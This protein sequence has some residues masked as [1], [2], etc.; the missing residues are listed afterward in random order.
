MENVNTNKFE[1]YILPSYIDILLLQHTKNLLIKK[2]K[3]EKFL[4]VFQQDMF[5]LL[6][7]YFLLLHNTIILEICKIT[8][9]PQREDDISLISFLEEKI[10]IDTINEIY[11]KYKRLRDKKI[12][13]L[14]TIKFSIKKYEKKKTNYFCTWNTLIYTLLR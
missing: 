4:N 13:H 6:A 10:E 5:S 1:S 8:Q 11:N 12:S 3:D 9:K 7:T 2:V 14:T